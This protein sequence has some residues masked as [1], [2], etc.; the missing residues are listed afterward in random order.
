MKNRIESVTKQ[1]GLYEPSI[2]QAAT[3]DPLSTAVSAETTALL[4]NTA[5]IREQTAVLQTQATAQTMNAQNQF[6]PQTASQ[7]SLTLFIA[8]DTEK[9]AVQIFGSQ[10]AVDFARRVFSSGSEYYGL[11]NA[12]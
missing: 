12:R 2:E 9:H 3:L 5:A 1:A 6:A 7:G 11:T 10:A 4:D 8:T